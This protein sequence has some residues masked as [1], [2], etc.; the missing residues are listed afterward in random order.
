[1]F[2]SNC[3]ANNADG[4]T[5]CQGCGAALSS[6]GSAASNVAMTAP[7]APKKPVNKKVI[8]GIGI[9]AVV[10]IIVLVLVIVLNKDKNNIHKSPESIANAYLEAYMSKDYEGMLDCIYNDVIEDREYRNR[11][12]DFAEDLQDFSSEVKSYK[13]EYIKE[14]TGEDLAE[15]IADYK[16]DYDVTIEGYAVAKV[17]FIEKDGDEDYDYLRLV[18]INGDWYVN[19]LD[20]LGY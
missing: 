13:Y 7:L 8:I 12:N 15:E 5:F 1:M 14:K 18:K 17:N 11:K 9:A 20:T 19:K 2:C 16:Y 4:S 10:A 3:G 6:D